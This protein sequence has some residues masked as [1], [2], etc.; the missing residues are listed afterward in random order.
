MVPGVL[1]SELQEPK[2][3]GKNSPF[4]EGTMASTTLLTG[5]GSGTCSSEAR[6][7][8]STLFIL[9]ESIHQA[10]ICSIKMY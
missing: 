8:R 5:S 2:E 10:T 1:V 4:P 6:K 7:G 9:K 3:A